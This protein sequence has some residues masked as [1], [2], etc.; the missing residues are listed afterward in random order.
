VLEGFP[1]Q[2]GKTSKPVPRPG[3]PELKVDDD[4]C[5]ARGKERPGVVDK[6]PIE[7]LGEVEIGEIE[8]HFALQAC[9]GARAPFKMVKNHNKLK[10]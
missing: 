8:V 7:E 3:H 1:V 2:S 10:Y 6:V 5:P 9:L 4:P